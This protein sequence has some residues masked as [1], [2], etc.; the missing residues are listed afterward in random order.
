MSTETFRK[1]ATAIVAGYQK[2][3]SPLSGVMQFLKRRRIQL[4]PKQSKL[5]KQVVERDI[6]PML[7]QV[8]AWTAPKRDADGEPEGVPDAKRQKQNAANGIK[9]DN[10]PL[11]II[12]A[13][14]A[15]LGNVLDLANL[16]T[17]SVA[18]AMGASRLYNQTLES[19]KRPLS[20]DNYVDYTNQDNLA[21][22]LNSK[23]KGVWYT[24]NI[25]WT[26][27]WM[28]ALDK[29]GVYLP[30]GNTEWIVIPNF[31]RELGTQVAARD[32]RE[33]RDPLRSLPILCKHISSGTKVDL[34]TLDQYLK[35]LNQYH[36]NTGSDRK[37]DL[38]ALVTLPWAMYQIPKRTAP[39]EVKLAVQSIETLITL[40]II[41]YELKAASELYWLQ[42]GSAR[43]VE[44][45]DTLLSNK[46]PPAAPYLGDVIVEQLPWVDQLM[47]MCFLQDLL[48]GYPNRLENEEFLQISK[49]MVFP[50]ESAFAFLLYQ[51]SKQVDIY[52]DCV[53]DLPAAAMAWFARC[54]A[55]SQQ[56]VDQCMLDPTIQF[57]LNDNSQSVDNHS[58]STMLACRSYVIC[59]GSHFD[60]ASMR[61][62]T[63]TLN[64]ILNELFSHLNASLDTPVE[65]DDKFQVAR[66][67]TWRKY[68]QMFAD[69]VSGG[70]YKV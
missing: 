21:R 7:S 27:R 70:P 52:S 45:L 30:T 42:N 22:L 9:L 17:A 38:S 32:L 53:K 13:I 47:H 16:R 14:A 4:T 33:Y 34:M 1:L 11:E 58:R 69:I 37:L 28:T 25:F 15:Q 61:A 68:V 67:E 43:V 51:M 12:E 24:Q 36:R 10:L 23:A 66:Y 2:G 54:A 26:L 6:E 41:F 55:T 49:R 31:S 62:E 65:K 40:I 60:W 39:P 56:Q 46:N 50:K 20:V 5:L 3:D 63:T 44:S 57:I 8:R 48:P 59:T 35:K 18:T 64:S 29:N 19:L